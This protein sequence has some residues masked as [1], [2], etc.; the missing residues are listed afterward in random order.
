MVQV[1][2]MAVLSGLSALLPDLMYLLARTSS[3]SHLTEPACLL[4]TSAALLCM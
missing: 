4:I 3:Y 2:H 1:A